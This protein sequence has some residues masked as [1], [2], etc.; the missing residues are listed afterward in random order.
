MAQKSLNYGVTP[1]DH[2][3]ES[4]FSIFKKIQENFVETYSK[5]NPLNFD[6]NENLV[7]NVSMRSGT[8]ASLIDLAGIVGEIGVC[9][10]RNALVVFNGVAGQAQ[11]FYRSREIGRMVIGSSVA[12]I[13]NNT[14][15]VVNISTT[16]LND[17]A[18]DQ[19]DLTNNTFTAPSYAAYVS[20]SISISWGDAG[21]AVSGSMRRV[22]IEFEASP[23][24][25]FWFESYAMAVPAFANATFQNITLLNFRD[26]ILSGAK[27]RITVQHVNG[28]NLNVTTSRLNV[29]WYA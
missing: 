13:A 5:T 27:H 17:F 19:I 6:V 11:P 18:S 22:S 29:V 15:T 16:V 28:G 1:E 4:L 10:D 20:I 3:G 26:Q 23:G 2:T 9:T 12:T 7:A 21:A 24:S 25:G 14:A 8:Y